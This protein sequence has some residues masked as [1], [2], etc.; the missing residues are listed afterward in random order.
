L[1]GESF[2]RKKSAEFSAQVLQILIF[3]YF[4]GENLTEKT[5]FLHEKH[6]QLQKSVGKTRTFNA[7]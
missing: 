4:G 1:Q 7:F 3:F 6:S 2:A 5:S